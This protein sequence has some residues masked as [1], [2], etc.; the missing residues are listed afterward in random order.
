MPSVYASTRLT[1]WADF[2]RWFL[3]E[4]YWVETIRLISSD[5]CVFIKTITSDQPDDD[6][7]GS[8]W[9]L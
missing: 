6:V 3:Y 5:M 2:P 9:D 7:Q 1:D 8:A 4:V